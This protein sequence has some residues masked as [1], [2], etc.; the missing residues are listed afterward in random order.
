MLIGGLWHGA[1]WSFVFWGLLHGIGLIVHKAFREWTTERK[2]INSYFLKGSS[3]I[4]TF[5]YVNFCW[6]F[7]RADN[8]AVGFKVIRQI[9]NNSEGI[10]Q[11]YT[12]TFFAGILLIV[13][14]IVRLYRQ[15][16]KQKNEVGEI[17]YFFFDLKSLAGLTAFFVL[18]GLTIIMGYYGN[19]A[20]IYGT[21]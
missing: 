16:T 17:S 8:I 4:F 6:I 10:H 5:M 20:F 9:F 12:W 15:R 11:P 14:S 7:F 21:F 3:I 1:D 13:S 19:T 18:I 2:T